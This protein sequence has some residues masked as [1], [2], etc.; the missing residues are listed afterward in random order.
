MIPI[1]I[2]SVTFSRSTLPFLFWGRWRLPWSNVYYREKIRNDQI[3][4]L[5]EKQLRK[6]NEKEEGEEEEEEKDTK[7]KKKKET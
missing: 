1:F 6:I 3:V 4:I 5:L 7:E 2:Y